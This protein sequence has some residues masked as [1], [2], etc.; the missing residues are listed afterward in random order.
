[1]SYFLNLDFVFIYFVALRSYRLCA[2][3]SLS[4]R[5]DAKNAK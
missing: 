1:M 4:S 3:L 5:K 2:I